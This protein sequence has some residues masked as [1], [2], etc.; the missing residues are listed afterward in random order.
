MAP[1]T[2]E[3]S[4]LALEGSLAAAPAMLRRRPLDRR[5]RRRLDAG[6]RSGDRHARSARRP[7]CTRRRRGARS[8]RRTARWPAWRGE[9]R[10][11]ALGDPAQM[12]RPDA[13]ERRRPRADPDH[14]AGQAAGRSEGRGARSA[15]RTSSGSPR[16]RSASTAT[17]F[18]RSRN[19]RRLVVVKEPV[20]V[21]AAITPWNFPC[22]MITRKV[23]P[24]LAAGCT[25]VIKPAEA[26]PFSALRARRA[27]ASRGIP[28]RRAQR[29]HRRRAVDRRRDVRESDGAQA[30]VH[31][32]DRSRPAADEAGRADDQEDLA[33]ARRQCAVHRVRRCR[34]R[35][36][37]R[38]RDRLQVPQRGPDLR[39]REP[40]LRA[41][42]GLRRVRRE[43]RGEGRRAQ[44]R[45]RH[46]RA[47]SR[48]AR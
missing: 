7:C 6:R 45:P 30:L 8:T 46:R 13:R 19:D 33:R 21:C 24:A 12:A 15:R 39:L 16:K 42:Q 20:G 2:I 43:A 11:G 48:R 31:R 14:R 32:L 35:C 38:R 36:G 5:R 41:R 3:R 1:D 9:D 44:G 23:A 4:P 22:S 26:T 37:G 10:E 27:R 40:L 47:A 18:R 25:V 28:A 34:P 29:H 17:S